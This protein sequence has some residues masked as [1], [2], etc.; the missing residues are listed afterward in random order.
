MHLDEGLFVDFV[1]VMRVNTA[2]VTTHFPLSGISLAPEPG[3]SLSPKESKLLQS[4]ELKVIDE[5]APVKVASKK[6]FLARRF[7]T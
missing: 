6:T 5:A 2:G 1:E 3:E 4:S 7:L